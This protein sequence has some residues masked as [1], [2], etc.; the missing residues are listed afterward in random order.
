MRVIKHRLTTNGFEYLVT[1]VGSLPILIG[2]NKCQSDYGWYLISCPFFLL[3]PR[4]A[5]APP[6][7]RMWWGKIFHAL[8]Y[9]IISAHFWL[10]ICVLDSPQSVYSTSSVAPRMKAVPF[11]P[12]RLALVVFLRL[13]ACWLPMYSD[14]SSFDILVIRGLKCVL[15]LKNTLGKTMYRGKA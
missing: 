6:R 7:S 8:V 9:T 11:L 10:A 5:T 14:Q 13:G 4:T 3:P 1:Y 15:F 12:S 2:C